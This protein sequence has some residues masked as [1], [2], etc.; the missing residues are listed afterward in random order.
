MKSAKPVIFISLLFAILTILIAFLNFDSLSWKKGYAIKSIEINSQLETNA[1]LRVNDQRTI[2]LDEST[3]V[4]GWDISRGSSGTGIRIDSVR[5]IKKNAAQVTENAKVIRVNQI[6]YDTRWSSFKAQE[7]QTTTRQAGAWCLN[8]GATQFLVFLPKEFC[9]TGEVVV[10]VEYSLSNFARVFDDVA[11]IY[12]D[13]FVNNDSFWAPDSAIKNPATMP[14]VKMRFGLPLPEKEVGVEGKNVWGW[15]HSDSGSVEWDESG[16]FVF[17]THSSSNSITDSRAHVLFRKSWLSNVDKDSGIIAG[18]ARVEG[19]IKEEK[20][21][22][23][24]GAY[25]MRNASIISVACVALA[26]LFAL[27]LLFAYFTCYKKF[28][29]LSFTK[30]DDSKRDIIV[31]Q[32]Y[33]KRCRKIFLF[34]A[35]L[36]AFLAFCASFYCRSSIGCLSFIV[37]VS[38]SLFL[39]NWLPTDL[40]DS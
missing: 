20:T 37:D 39:A 8:A 4:V 13:Y 31:F 10:E 2:D 6:A 26:S 34:C 21:W 14:E 9:G 12:W 18:G 7:I 36:F 22:I 40:I 24:S 28:S 32:N 1:V 27:A 35:C 25:K 29:H 19:A 3:K 11:E 38:L 17:K 30:G 23:D 33:A 16:S 15:G 5:I